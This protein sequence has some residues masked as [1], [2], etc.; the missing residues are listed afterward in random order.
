MHIISMRFQDENA[1]PIKELAPRVSAFCR[2]MLVQ[3][4]PRSQIVPAEI[5]RKT[6]QVAG[7]LSFRRPRFQ[8]RIIDADVF[9]FGIQT[10]K[11]R[12]KFLRTKSSSYFFQQGSG[13]CQ[14]LTH[15]ICQ[16]LGAPQKHPAVPKI[17]SRSHKRCSLFGIGLLGE[18]EYAKSVSLEQSARFNVPVAG[19]CAI[20]PDTE[21][22]NIL[23]GR[24]NLHSTLDARAVVIFIR[25]YVIRR[26]HSDHRSGIF[27]QK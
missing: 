9:A 21:D 12:S 1:A 8:N 13:G 22:D 10:A 18:T 5:G 14:M 7:L 27:A 3:G 25:D 19:F 16:S 23:T 6:K 15:R 26:K 20:W 2:V 4:S 24:R 11:S 17:I